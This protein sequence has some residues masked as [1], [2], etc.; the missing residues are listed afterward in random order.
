MDSSE[1][2][3]EQDATGSKVKIVLV[4]A[5]GGIAARAEG[6]LDRCWLSG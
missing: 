5:Q 6:L 3:Q 1:V 2:V 4:H